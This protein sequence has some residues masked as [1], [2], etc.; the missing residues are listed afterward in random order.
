MPTEVEIN[1][2]FKDVDTLRYEL[3]ECKNCNERYVSVMSMVNGEL[4]ELT[5]YRQKLS[6]F[7]RV[8]KKLEDL[9]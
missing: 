2:L 6:M 5:A 1:E 8:A 3:K 7:V 4:D 9:G